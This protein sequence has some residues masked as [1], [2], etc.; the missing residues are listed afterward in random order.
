MTPEQL[1]AD[2]NAVGRLR[3]D[4]Q[5]AL[6]VLGRRDTTHDAA[7]GGRF[8]PGRLDLRS[9]RLRRADLSEANLAYA[10]LHG[11]DL[12]GAYLL[13]AD[14]NAANVGQA[15]LRNAFL[16]GAKLGAQVRVAL[17]FAGTSA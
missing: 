12:S 1:Q 2:P 3:A 5:A 9:A 7:H 8:R 4:L 6:T 16:G 13:Q 11:V 10:N 14:L 15:N 17:V